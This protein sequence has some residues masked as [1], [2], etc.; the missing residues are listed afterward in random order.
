[1]VLV[2]EHEDTIE[3]LV[4]VPG[5]RFIDRETMGDMLFYTEQLEQISSSRQEAAHALYVGDTDRWPDP[6]D[7][8]IEETFGAL[9]DRI[10]EL[11]HPPCPDCEGEDYRWPED[12]DGDTEGRPL[13]TL[14]R[15]QRHRPR[16]WSPR[17]RARTRR[18]RKTLAGPLSVER[19]LERRG[20]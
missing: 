10:D 14:R 4:M 16:P 12:D 20:G 5:E 6:A 17:R 9:I 3:R 11:R 1:M 18:T 13:P 8:E 19:L 2:D 7:S 15:Q